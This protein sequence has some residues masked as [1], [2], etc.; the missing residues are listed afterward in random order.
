MVVPHIYCNNADFFRIDAFRGG[1]CDTATIARLERQLD[2]PNRSDGLCCASLPEFEPLPDRL[3]G[4]VLLKVGDNVST[5]EILQAGAKALPYRSNIP[6]I[7]KLRLLSMFNLPA[8]RANI[9]GR[10]NYDTRL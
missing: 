1:L 10:P 9:R 4:P 2:G 8:P 7:S 5:D 6:E 3:A